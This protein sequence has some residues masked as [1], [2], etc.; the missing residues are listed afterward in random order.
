MTQILQLPSFS[1]DGTSFT[2]AKNADWFDSIFFIHP[3]SPTSPI[4]MYVSVIVGS[5]IATTDS[6]VGLIPGLPITPV[7]INNKVIIDAGVV[8]GPIPSS[9][10]FEMRDQYTNAP[11]FAQMTDAALTMIFQPMPLDLTGIEFRAE[12]RT[13]ED[14]EQVLLSLQ[15]SDNTLLNGGLDGTLGFNVT[16]AQLEHLKAR[17]YV[18]DIVASADG[19]VINLFPAGPGTVVVTEGVTVI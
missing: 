17:T 8:V 13:Q 9:T 10:T 4:E 16:S 15:S 3:Y 2:I 14:S 5:Y 12:L 6:V 18:M 1:G 19:H 11:A 7:K